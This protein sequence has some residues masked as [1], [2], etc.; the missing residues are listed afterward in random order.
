M[1]KR[2]RQPSVATLT[3]SKLDH[4]FVWLRCE[5]YETV[6]Q[7]VNKPHAEGPAIAR[8]ATAAQNDPSTRPGDHLGPCA[9]TLEDFEERAF[10]NFGIPAD[11]QLVDFEM[12][13]EKLPEQVRG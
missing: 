6:R 9:R 11:Q 2:I 1:R 5:T 3:E 4:V 10:R 13:P 8:T 12:R 7:R